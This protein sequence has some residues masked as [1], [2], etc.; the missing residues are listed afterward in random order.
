MQACN[1]VYT[2]D[3]DEHLKLMN[4]NKIFYQWS[5]R[6]EISDFQMKLLQCL[7]S[8]LFSIDG[9]ETYLRPPSNMILHPCSISERTIVFHFIP[10]EAAIL[11]SHSFIYTFILIV[12]L[13]L[14]ELSFIIM[15]ML[16]VYFQ[17]ILYI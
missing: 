12:N 15:M 8:I 7:L 2:D 14:T 11:I 13:F 17:Y 9:H 16:L 1:F 6:F 5:Y 4:T 10:L 3:D